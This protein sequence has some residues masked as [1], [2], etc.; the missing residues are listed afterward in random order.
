M[1]DS[2]SASKRKR[3]ST[4][5]ESSG[6]ESMAST[7]SHPKSKHK[8]KHRSSEKDKSSRK[9]KHRSSTTDDAA[10][11]ASEAESD[12]SFASSSSSSK[13]KKSSRKSSKSTS[14]P[15]S[16][17]TQPLASAFELQYPIV[18]LSIPP[19]H[20]SQPMT[21]LVETFD[22]L[23]MRFVPPL[24]GVLVSHGSAFFLDQSPGAKE[25]RA[26][27]ASGNAPPASAL[28]DADGAWAKNS[29]AVECCVWRPKIGM[30]IGESAYEDGRFRQQQMT[31]MLTPGC[32]PL[33]PESGPPRL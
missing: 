5:A 26:A 18:T 14:E 16:L 4:G 8:S 21:A 19:V 2:H 33:P 11:S 32:L 6:D 25:A 31:A 20:A 13:K 27:P 29:V 7:S 3:Y 23:V 22:S 9:S 28:I 17:L 12:A 15:S 10:A 30:K 24:N 1:S